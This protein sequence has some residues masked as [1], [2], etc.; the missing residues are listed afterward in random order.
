MKGRLPAEVAALLPLARRRLLVSR[1]ARR[2]RDVALH[3][4][5]AQGRLLLLSR[6]TVHR[7]A[8]RV[9]YFMADGTPAGHASAPTHLAGLHAATELGACLETCAP[10]RSLR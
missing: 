8:W 9:T 3:F 7:S 5:D 6:D 1:L 10:L 2:H 4:R